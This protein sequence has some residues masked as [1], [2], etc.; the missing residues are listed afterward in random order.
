MVVKQAAL[1][2]AMLAILTGCG[3]GDSDDPELGASE[4]APIPEPEPEVR[5]FSNGDLSAE[6]SL[7]GQIPVGHYQYTSINPDGGAETVGVA[8]ISDTGRVALALPSRLSFARIELNESDRFENTLEDTE[9]E[10][11]NSGLTITGR[12]DNGVPEG[13]NPRV[14]GTFLN[15]DTQSIN[16]N[17][18]LDLQDA[19]AQSL[20][21]SGL[22]GTFSGTD[23]SGIGT[24]ISL[25]SDGSLMGSGTA[26]CD[27]AG[28]VRI[29]D[30]GQEIF[31][32]KFTASNCGP[33]DT[34]SAE[35]RNGDYFGV[36]RINANNRSITLFSTNGAVGTRFTGNSTASEDQVVDDEVPPYTADDFTVEPSIAAKLEPGVYDYTDIP[37]ESSPSFI[38]SGLMFVTNTG[39]IGLATDVRYAVARVRV[40]DVDTFTDD[41]T[42]NRNPQSSEEPTPAE[43]LFGTPNNNGSSSNFTISGSLLDSEGEL[44]NR[45]DAERDTSNDAQYSGTPLTITAISGTYSGTRN[46]GAITTTITIAADGEVT[47]SDTTG[48]NL[49]G[50]AH[51][52]DGTTGMIE[53]RL[54]VSNCTASTTKTG[55]ERNGDYNVVGDWTPGSPDLLRLVMG[56]TDNVEYLALNL[57]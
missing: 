6:A 55:E 51:I 8:F 3:G 17:Y 4:G 31:E 7:E 24:V 16:R 14:S 28:Q 1:A 12:R 48:C 36:G 22:A 41:L 32:V 35:A 47:G 11:S 40:N 30:S 21:L 2:T 18:K 45:Y 42:Q 44:T 29:P 5:L 56:S 27:Y 54:A 52:E 50:N 57:Q 25:N 43:T 19:D 34:L 37:L 23:D 39:R 49:L 33:T 10:I 13:Q 9:T 53:M 46:P 38:E 15:N 26:G 20:D